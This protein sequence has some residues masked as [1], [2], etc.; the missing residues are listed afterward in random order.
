MQKRV[1]ALAVAVGLAV[2]ALPAF[3]ADAPTEERAKA[4]VKSM[5]SDESVVAAVA[6]DASSR[7]RESPASKDGQCDKLVAAIRQVVDR[8]R[9]IELL[10]PFFAAQF[11]GDEV[12]AL[13]GF[14]GGDAGKRMTAASNRAFSLGAAPSMPEVD[15]A[16]LDKLVAFQ[17]TPAARK[18][19]A[20]AA[21]FRDEATRRVGPYLCTLLQPTGLPCASLTRMA[22]AAAAPVMLAVFPLQR[23]SDALDAFQR[24]ADIVRARHLLEWAK[25]IAA[26]Y[27]K[28]GRYPLQHRVKGGEL[29]RVR[30]ATREQQSFLDPAHGNYDKSIALD[31]PRFTLVSMKE[32]VA[33]IEAVLGREIDERYDPQRVPTGAPNYFSY[34]ATKDG[35]L[36][37]AI[38]RTCPPEL[39]AVTIPLPPARTFNI[40][41][42]WF[43]ENVPGTQSLEGLQA[44]K[45][46]VQFVGSGPKRTGSFEGLAR[47]Q[48]RETKR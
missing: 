1:V 9:V 38:C 42:A 3:A 45:A 16:V 15:Q 21:K 20:L 8:E 32:F 7:C 41:S 25:L 11:S 30:I 14:Y 26:Y 18:L 35:Y 24:D 28:S 2:L 43:I 13:I 46:F 40:G 17:E 23:P 47:D 48:A 22:G 19:A 37:W 33:D 39:R 10:A 34:F 4:L 5:R 12:E 36:I 6:M 27:E 44:N 31:D 29:L